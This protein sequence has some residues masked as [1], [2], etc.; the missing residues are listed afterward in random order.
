MRKW[1]YKIL[2]IFLCLQT[3]QIFAQRFLMD[4]VD[5]TNHMGKG[6]L[7]IYERYNRL[8]VSG[9]IQPQFQYIQT[10]GAET[11]SGGNF[12]PL[13]NNRF[14]IRRGRLR[15]DYAHLNEKD[16]LTTDFVFQF[17]GTERGV[18]I[19][20]FWGRFYD[21]KFKLFSVTTGMFARPF[22]YEVNLASANRETP[23]RGRMS[24]ILMRT[25]RDIGIMLTFNDRNKGSKWNKLKLDVGIFN[26]QGM[27]GPVDYDSHKDIIARVSLK[28]TRLFKLSRM[29][30]SA[31]ISGYAG[32]ITSQS[33][34]LYAT[35]RVSDNYQMMRDSSASN[36][37]KNSPRN[38]SGADMQLVFPNGFGETEFRAEYIRGKQTATLL[39][40][41]TPGIYPVT[42]GLKDPL[43]ARNF[44]GAYFY[45][46]QHLGSPKH[47]FV[48]K[49]DWYDP[50]TKVSGSSV[51]TDA[52]GFSKADLKYNTLGF[53]YVYYANSSLKFMLYYDHVRNEKSGLAGFNEDI[54]DDVFT[55]RVQYNF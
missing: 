41:E 43:Y 34:V 19:R 25:E 26:G 16:E 8:K 11:F 46:L 12:A 3:E 29:L 18:A 13:S 33:N 23:E 1:I 55:C 9:Y 20:D 45:F 10:E 53:G 49:Y 21:N 14:M 31:G 42:N 52:R 28:P 40:S 54:P 4:L 6:M 22:G 30:V 32:G 15:I 37:K 47:Q 50:N 38:Y 5:T 2:V 17:D 51:I 39:S 27:S 35:K 44:N 7:S 24:Q 36:F 48:A